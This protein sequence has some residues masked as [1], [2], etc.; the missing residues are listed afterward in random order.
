MLKFFFLIEFKEF[1][2]YYFEINLI[3]IGWIRI[4]MDPELL[5]GSGTRK[6]QS[7]IRNKSFRIHNTDKNWL[8]FALIRWQSSRAGR[9]PCSR[10]PELGLCPASGSGY[11]DKGGQYKKLKPGD[12]IAEP[13]NFS[14]KLYCIKKLNT[15]QKE[16]ARRA[17][18]KP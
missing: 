18:A 11:W 15:P 9:R 1:F 13:A 4:G 8:T 10:G 6:I 16:L 12:S 14:G 7:W 5:P 3:N 17:A 2:W